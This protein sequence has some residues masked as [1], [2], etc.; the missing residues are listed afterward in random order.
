MLG[1]EFKT[2]VFYTSIRNNRVSVKVKESSMSFTK[3]F[4]TAA[5]E[6]PGK[7][8]LAKVVHLQPVHQVRRTPINQS[9]K[10]FE[11]ESFKRF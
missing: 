6:R 5:I 9:K 4:K 8:K 1:G 11:N 7:K 2:L 3:S 10:Q